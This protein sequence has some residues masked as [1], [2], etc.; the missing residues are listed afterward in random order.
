MLN[1]FLVAAASASICIAALAAEPAGDTVLVQKGDVTVT[2]DDFLAAMSK[3][4]EDQRA[5]YRADIERI[6]NAV[7]SVYVNRELAAEARSQGIDKDPDFQHRLKLAEES[8]LTQAYLDRFE[9]SIVVPDFEAKAKELYASNPARYDVPASVSVKQIFISFQGRSPEEAKRLA[10][11]A[12]AKLIADE[13]FFKV[14]RQYSNDPT[15]RST[16]G[17]KQ[18]AYRVFPPA[19]AAVAKVAELNKPSEPI[20][21][22]DGYYVIVVQERLPEFTVPFEKVKRELVEAEAAKYRRAKIDE[23]LGTV[24][25]SKEITLYTDR[26]AALLVPVDRDRLKAL[27]EE[28]AQR[29]AEEKARILR[30]GDKKPAGS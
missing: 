27:H 22:T 19:V 13:P 8:M 15:L 25:K 5:S 29:D 26:I 30:E 24:T 16:D 7:S 11:E 14:V 21:S 9:K 20:R 3:L 18:G 4:P 2:V 1:K 28:K 23:K 17:Y 10:E 12:R 6:T